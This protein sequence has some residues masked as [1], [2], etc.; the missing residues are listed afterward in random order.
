MSSRLEN[1]LTL[2]VED[3]GAQYFAKTHTPT[4]TLT[5]THTLFLHFCCQYLSQ[6]PS[7]QMCLSIS[8][9]P[10]SRSVWTCHVNATLHPPL[11][12]LSPLF[13]FIC[14]HLQVSQH[15]WT[16]H[17]YRFTRR[18]DLCWYSRQAVTDRCQGPLQMLT[19]LR[20]QIASERLGPRTR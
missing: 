3:F 7:D 10:T 18:S 4:H 9:P 2:V 15:W 19:F 14:I 8:V 13:T 11:C 16:P 5:L 20:W 12:H 17:V 6:S 1:V